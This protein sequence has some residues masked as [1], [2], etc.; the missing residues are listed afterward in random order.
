MIFLNLFLLIKFGGYPWELLDTLQGL[1]NIIRLRNPND[2]LTKAEM[3]TS[4]D[5]K[6]RYFAP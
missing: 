5:G 6:M 1:K 3:L 4:E 2:F